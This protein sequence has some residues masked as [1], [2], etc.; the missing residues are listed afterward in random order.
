MTCESVDLKAYVL[1][2]MPES[3]KALVAG[4]VRECAS[5]GEEMERLSLTHLAL[6]SLR[7]EE[8][9]RRIAFVS[10]KVF[11]PR[12]WQRVWRS[13]PVMGFASAAVLACAILAHGLLPPIPLAGPSASV[14][15]AAVER[16]VAAEVSERVNARVNAVVAEAVAKAVSDADA[17]QQ[18]RTA[19]LLAGVQN[20]YDLERR[21]DM[22]AVEANLEIF[23]KEWA[24]LYVASNG[25]EVK[26]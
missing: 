22:L 4:H 18:R 17:R 11:E 14:D 19:E 9:P 16:R 6:V 20:K 5:C 26:P 10:D 8:V 21:A 1:G 23:R 2:E 13:G 25:L 15:S 12:W 7:D 24:R 3:E